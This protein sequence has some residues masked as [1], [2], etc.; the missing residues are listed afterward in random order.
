MLTRVFP[1]LDWFKGYKGSHFRIDLIAGITVAL[2][3]ISRD[4]MGVVYPF[5]PDLI[6]YSLLVLCILSLG[7]FGIR[8]QN[9]FADNKVLALGGDTRSIYKNSG[10]KEDLA[11]Q[12]HRELKELMETEKPY[13][14]PDL[15]LSAMAERLDVPL[16]HLSQIIN[17]LEEQ[18]FNDFVNKYRVEEFIERA[19]RDKQFS[20]LALALDS[21][22]NSK[23]TFNAVFKKHKGV[24]PSRY[25]ANQALKG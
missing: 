17:Q 20:F 16:H 23:S 2:V 13:L 4:I 1:F 6:F 21:G 25:M 18:N 15:T 22:F 14:E 3:L 8:H 9:V 11:H 10:L 19:S 5:N 7:Y 24:T 12:K